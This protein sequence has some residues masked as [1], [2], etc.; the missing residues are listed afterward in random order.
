MELGGVGVGELGFAFL[1]FLGGDKNHTA[2]CCRTVEGC[3]RG[4]WE[5]RHRLDVVGV[6]VGYGAWTRLFCHSTAFFRTGVDVEHGDTV[7]HVEGIVVACKRFG[8]THDHTRCRTGACWACADVD[9]GYLTC[10]GVDEVGV[11]VGCEGV[12]FE[13]LYVVGQSFLFALDTECGHY[14]FVECSGFL[15]HDNVHL[16]ACRNG[17]LYGTIANV[18]EFDHVALFGIEVEFTIDVGGCALSGA[19]DYYGNADQGFTAGVCHYT[20]DRDGLRHD[21]DHREE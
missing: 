15:F 12:A 17:E 14:Y 6:D 21:A 1:T 10:E 5:Y 13:C 16:A 19:F 2:G 8:T 3:C 20:L 11:L 4:T 7:D 9:T 18:W